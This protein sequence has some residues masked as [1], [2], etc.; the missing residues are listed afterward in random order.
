MNPDDS[1]QLFEII[2]QLEDMFAHKGWKHLED[3]ITDQTIAVRENL[4]NAPAPDVHVLQGQLRT[5]KY[6]ANLPSTVE[7]WRIN[8]TEQDQPVRTTSLLTFL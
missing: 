4:E 3:L 2:E 6:I 7:L 1:T 8:A 5:L